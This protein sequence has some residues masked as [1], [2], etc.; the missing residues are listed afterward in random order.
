M[1]V[2]STWMA[3]VTI[4]GCSDK[5]GHPIQAEDHISAKLGGEA[6]YPSSTVRIV[7]IYKFAK[8]NYRW[9]V[10][11]VLTPN[12]GAEILSHIIYAKNKKDAQRAGEFLFPPPGKVVSVRKL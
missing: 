9:L 2:Y 7:K 4:S 1:S 11:G 8:S 12:K 10:E 5:I 6:L 3:E